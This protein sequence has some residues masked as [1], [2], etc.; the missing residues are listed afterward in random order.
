MQTSSGSHLHSHKEWEAIRPIFIRH[1]SH[2]KESL[3]KVQETLAKDHLFY[4]T[5]VVIVLLLIY[6]SSAALGF[7][8]IRDVSANGALGR[9]DGYVNYW[10]L[11][12]GLCS[13][14][15]TAKGPLQPCPQEPE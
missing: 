5:Y 15:L 9:T 2:N 11:K 3:R 8:C 6:F 7:Q 1:Y 4:A 10:T 13:K 12:T 14:P